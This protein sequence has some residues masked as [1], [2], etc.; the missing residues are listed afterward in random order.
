MYDAEFIRKCEQC[1][2]LYS[3]VYGGKIDMEGIIKEALDTLLRE[4][5]ELKKI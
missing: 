3:A 5:I 4:L 1:R 2:L